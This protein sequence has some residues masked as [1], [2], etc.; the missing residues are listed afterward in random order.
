M[1]M[2]IGKHCLVVKCK[3]DWCKV[4]VGKYSGWVKKDSL[5]G[6]LF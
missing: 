2:E 4:R 5:W 3:K 1:T 6:R